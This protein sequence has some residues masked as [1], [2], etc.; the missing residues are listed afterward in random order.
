MLTSHQHDRTYFI[1]KQLTV[2]DQQ[3]QAET[4]IQ[5]AEVNGLGLSKFTLRMVREKVVEI[6]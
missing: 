6:I 3:L 1:Q 2:S 4:S 5:C